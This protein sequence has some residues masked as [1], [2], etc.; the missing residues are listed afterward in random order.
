MSNAS[1]PIAKGS[2]DLS[3]MEVAGF[4]VTDAVFPPMLALASHY[5]ERTCFAVVLEGSVDKAFPRTEYYSPA[6][7]AI[8]MPAEERHK[9]Q[10]Q[11]VGAHML[12]IE[13]GPRTEE[14]V[15]PC[16]T[17]LDQVNHFRN[18][19]VVALAWRMSRELRHPDAVSHL[20][21]E[22]LALEMLAAAARLLSP[23]PPEKHPPPW[24]STAEEFVRASFMEHFQVADLASQVGVHP[25]HLSRV[26]R[27]HFGESLGQYV[28]RLRLDWAAGQLTTS[29]VAL[30][31]LAGLAG[32]A[33]QSHFTRAFKCHT[34]LTP[35]QYRQ[36]TSRS[37]RKAQ[38][39]T[40][41]S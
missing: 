11:R 2:V 28:R 15:R 5:H 14:V 19:G 36:S 27:A 24:L 17:V 3:V 31:H 23:A 7:T 41:D 8:T 10:F 6:S 26:F 22:G 9:D 1:A 21:I 16:S 34:G 39:T 13:P 25:V 35:A 12:V 33:D 37:E 20:A 38:R 32:F 18:G 30:T 4:R 29:D 40:Q